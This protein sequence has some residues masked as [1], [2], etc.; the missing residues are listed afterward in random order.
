MSV[1]DSLLL[2]TGCALATFLVGFLV[3]K[4]VAR[5]EL[6]IE[7]KSLYAGMRELEEL[8]EEQV[9]EL[10]RRMETKRDIP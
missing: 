9:K 5:K 1:F 2:A 10:M 6:Q 3:G 4:L 8:R 7:L